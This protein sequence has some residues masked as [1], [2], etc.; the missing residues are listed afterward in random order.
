MQAQRPNIEARMVEV[1]KHYQDSE[2]IAYQPSLLMVL[3]AS[4]GLLVRVTLR[5]M[6]GINLQQPMLLFSD[7]G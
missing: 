3:Q 1:D 6:D 5:W 2:T 7:A 4:C